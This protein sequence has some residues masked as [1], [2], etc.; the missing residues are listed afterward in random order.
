MRAEPR[1]L[2]PVRHRIAEVLRASRRSDAHVWRVTVVACELLTLSIEQGNSADITLRLLAGAD[3]TRVEVIDALPNAPAFDSLHGRLV[4]RAAS[5]WGVLR[6]PP[7]VR[8][9]WCDVAR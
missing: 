2:A 9:L 7:G 8:T 4:V 1:Q 6:E 3:G 5:S